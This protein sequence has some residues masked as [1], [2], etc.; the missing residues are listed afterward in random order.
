[1]ASGKTVLDK[2]GTKDVL[3]IPT[4]WLPVE[5]LA[6]LKRMISAGP[7]LTISYPTVEGDKTALFLVNQPVYKSFKYGEDG[8]TQWYGV[9]LTAEQQGVD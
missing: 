8:V 5:D 6:S 9:T 2:V 1:M 7:E 3:E 4:G